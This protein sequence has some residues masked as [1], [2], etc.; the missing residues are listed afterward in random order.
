MSIRDTLTTHASLMAALLEHAGHL[1][2]AVSK[3]TH[4]SSSFPRCV[5]YVVYN[6]FKGHHHEGY[7]DDV[8]AS[9]LFH[10]KHLQNGSQIPNDP[11]SLTRPKWISQMYTNHPC[12]KIVCD[13]I[14]NIEDAW[15]S[16]NPKEEIGSIM[17]QA[18]DDILT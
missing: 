10:Q 8:E 12:R 15:G 4:T 6:F 2:E 11:S 3:T 14:T 9:A 7:I 1:S 5:R 13:S 18:I 17:K 16:W